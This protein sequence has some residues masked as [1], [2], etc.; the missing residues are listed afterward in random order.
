[1]QSAPRQ[2][3]SQR[4]G[5][6]VADFSRDGKSMRIA[7]LTDAPPLADKGH[8]CHTLSRN[9]I[10]HLK[11]FVAV[12]ITRRMRR[13]LTFDE[14]RSATGLETLFYPDLAILPE[15]LGEVKSRLEILLAR[16][17]VSKIARKIKELGV[18]RL[19][20][21]CGADPW[22]LW[23]IEMFQKATGLPTD[24]YL[25]DDFESSAILN[26]N[27]KFAEKAAAWERRI[28]SRVGRVF[29]ISKG[30][31]ERI[32]AKTG[33]KSAW[34]PIPIPLPNGGIR[35]RPH[36]HD[37]KCGTPLE[38][39]YLG[40]INP[41]YTGAI[42]D[43]LEAIGKINKTGRRK[44]RLSIMS[45][46]EPEV[47]KRQLGDELD[48]DYFHKMPIEE[49][50]KR[51]EKSWLIFMPYTF[52]KAHSVM[53]STSFPS[54]LAETLRCGR[55]LLVYGPQYASLPRYFKE[56]GANICV[57]DKSLL[58]EALTYAEKYDNPETI[59]TYEK[60]ARENHSESA[61]VGILGFSKI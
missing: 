31:C 13:N 26:G 8:G 29:A 5:N 20:A 39:A 25:V 53:V 21:C 56:T 50:R 18:A 12:V 41:L 33:I 3:E 47:I 43:L 28:L 14:I 6:A 15:R 37:E 1:M 44:M 55:P 34:L 36:S 58:L 51:L 35:Y 40:A 22:F 7:F 52:E 59:K 27:L 23:I 17:A 57:M 45:Y 30:F 32:E 38:I 42:L 19:F 46:T 9:L 24:V 60:I 2:F 48:Y 49:C 61:L 16:A 10:S 54:R 11:Q 4:T